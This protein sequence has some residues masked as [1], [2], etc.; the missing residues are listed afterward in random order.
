MTDIRNS[1]GI[2]AHSEEILSAER[3]QRVAR[4]NGQNWSLKEAY[5]RWEDISSRYE[6]NWI[7][8]PRSDVDLWN[9]W[10]QF[11]SMMNSGDKQ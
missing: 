6:L 1:Y 2:P 4:D 10:L 7:A 9:V 11:S 3:F 5:Q 8:M